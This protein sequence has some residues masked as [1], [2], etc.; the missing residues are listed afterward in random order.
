MYETLAMSDLPD[1]TVGG[2]I[3]IVVNNQV[4]LQN[5]ALSCFCAAVTGPPCRGTIY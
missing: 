1:Y 4:R 5:L 3:H 2:T